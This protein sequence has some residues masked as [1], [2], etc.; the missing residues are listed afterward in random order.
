MH[1]QTGKDAVVTRG[2]SAPLQVPVI[3]H[4]QFFT[5]HCRLQFVE[6][7]I[8]PAGFGDVVLAAPTILAQAAS[9]TVEVRVVSSDST[10]V[11][12]R[13]EIF[14]RIKAITCDVGETAGTTPAPDGAMGLG[15]VLNQSHLRSGG[16][17]GDVF[18]LGHLTVEV[19]DD[20]R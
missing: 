12:D 18:N 7:A 19:G 20:Y 4:W 16:Q 14:G 3:E 15:T 17:G 8:A 5:R 10:A 11:A 2:D 1:G 13:P 9:S 6:P